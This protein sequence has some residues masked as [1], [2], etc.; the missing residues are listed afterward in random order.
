MIRYSEEQINQLAPDA[1]ALKSG[2]DLANDRKWLALRQTERAV[3]GEVQ[4]SGSEPYRA[5]VDFDVSSF[6]HYF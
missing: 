1:S 2:R 4:G 3:W 6:N 5:A